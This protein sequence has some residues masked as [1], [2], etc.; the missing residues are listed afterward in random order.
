MTKLIGVLTALAAAG[1]LIYYGFGNRQVRKE[2]SFARASRQR[3]VS[4]IVTNG[5]IEPS[6]YAAVR[7][8]RDGAVVR[9]A[10]EKGQ[11]VQ[12]GQLIA[13]IESTGLDAEMR[14]AES[15][16][17]QARAELQVIDRGGNAAALTDIDNGLAAA[18]L[19]LDAARREKEKTA[20]LVEK[21][22][23]TPQALT[24]ATDRLA[25][26][27]A[28]VEALNRSRAAVLPAGVREPVLARLREAEAA[29]SLIEQRVAQSAV[30]APSAGIVYNVALRSGAFV[31]SGD[32]IAELGRTGA[33]NAIV[34]V[35]EPELGRVSKGTRV[36]ITWDAMPDRTWDAV[37]DK[38]PTQIVALNSRQVGEVIC[39]LS[40]QGG[41]L[42]PGA[43]INAEIVSREVAAALAIPKAALRREGTATGVLVLTQPDNK[44]AWRP[45]QIGISSVTQVEVTGGLRESELVALPGASTVVAGELV[46][47]KAP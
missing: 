21:H 34:Y 14:G 19:E 32:L 41:V 45:V 47:P 4:S 25:Q 26:I 27:E 46:A 28:R 35:D 18:R 37:V 9:L 13:E 7:A 24:A 39:A 43:N 10:V 5:K 29:R 40:N 12:A 20:R 38:L 8:P 16:I 1:A 33:V 31:H 17:A 3:L 23:E 30:R 42:S 44:L 15:R 2:V 22:A 6:G 36:K 11:A